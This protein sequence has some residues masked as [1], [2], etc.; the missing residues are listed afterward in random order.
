MNPSLIFEL[1]CIEG[2]SLALYLYTLIAWL[3]EGLVFLKKGWSG[4]FSGLG[5][6]GD[7]VVLSFG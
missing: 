2:E 3:R 6:F 1:L 7:A 5:G 4:V